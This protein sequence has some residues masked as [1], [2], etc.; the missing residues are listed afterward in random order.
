[1]KKTILYFYFI[2][3]F[4]LTYGQTIYVNSETG[5]DQ[6]SGTIKE[7]LKT[8]EAGVRLINNFTGTT[9]VTLKLYPGLYLLQAN[10]TIEP[11]KNL[12][13]SNRLTIE[14]VILPDDTAWRHE[15]MPTIISTSIPENIEGDNCTWTFNIK[16]N[17]VTIRGIKFL[18]NP[19]LT[20]KHF[21]IYRT[22]DTLTDLK[23]SQC[24]FLGDEY[25][26]PVDVA[27]LTNGHN[28]EVEHCLF[29]NCHW[30]VIFF[31]AEN[32]NVPI[33]KSSMHHCIITDCDGGALW[34]SLVESDFRFYNNIVNNCGYFWVKNYFNKAD[35]TIR[36]CVVTDVNVYNGEWKENNQVEK[37]EYN[38][39]EKNILKD[40]SIELVKRNA[41]SYFNIE[42]NFMHPAKGS[43]GSELSAGIF[44]ENDK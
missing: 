23:V 26:L 11:N 34:T 35:Y 9:P 27:V 4:N 41:S 16:S 24:L 12:T 10:L 2:C 8:I 18:G 37:G 42:R 32:W 5:S 43:L 33:R 3:L 13:P 22:V 14:A 44:M 1:M 39:I 19:S 15:N 6:N 38:F 29:Y 28:A 17:H 31:H 7:P 20:T 25:A 36:D 21:P 40:G 30:A